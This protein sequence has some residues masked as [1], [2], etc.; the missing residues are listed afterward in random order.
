[1]EEGDHGMSSVDNRIVN[2]QF[3]NK[4]FVSGAEDSAQ[5]LDTLEKSI[6]G[7]SSSDS[8][9]SELGASVDT[10]A[11]RFGALQ[12]AGIAALATIASQATQTA[13]S[14]GRDLLGSITSTIFG[15]GFARAKD[16]QQAKFQFRGLGLDVQ[17][18]MDNASEAVD[19]TAFALNEAASIATQFGGSGVKAG[20]DMTEA[21]RAVSG[22]A[23]QTGRSYS[24][25]G[26]VMTGIAGVG[27]VTS[28]DIIQ[29]GVRGLDVIGP[30]AEQLGKTRNQIKQMVTDGQIDFKTFAHAMD[31]AFGENATK[32]NRTFTG[33]LANMQTA[34]K[35]IGADFFTGLLKPAGNVFN[36][37]QAVFKK[38]QEVLEPVSGGFAKVARSVSD[39]TVK[40]LESIHV[41]HLLG[42]ILQ[43][44]HNLF[45]PIVALFHTIGEAWLE[46]FPNSQH[47]SRRVL[48]TLAS[49]FKLITT[50]LEWLAKLIPF[51]SPLFVAFFEILRV[52][53]VAVAGLSDLIVKLFN[54]LAAGSDIGGNLIQGLIDGIQSGDL[55]QAIV[56]LA[57]NIIT[58]IKDVLGIHS[59]AESM[60]EIGTNIIMGIIDGL[61]AAVGFLWQTL[62]TL[63]TGIIEGIG[64]AFS[65][66]EAGDIAALI[67]AALLGGIFVAIRGVVKT[68]GR[69]ADSLSKISTTLTAPF[70]LLTESLKV[71]QT[72]V[73]A[74]LIKSIAIA[75]GILTVSL[76]ALSLM[77]FDKLKKGLG[78]LASEL[79]LIIGTMAALGKINPES[80]VASGAAIV[81]IS[82]AMVLLTAAL[83]GLALIPADQIGKALTTLAISLT[84][85]VGAVEFLGSIGPS[86]LAGAGA[87]AIVAAAMIALATAVGAFAL[88]PADQV[89]KA[90]TTLAISL[91]LVV[92][93]VAGLGS[94][95][96]AALAGAGGIFIVAQAMIVLAAAVFAF[97][98][99]NPNKVGQALTTMAI[100][101][102]EIVAALAL[103]TAIGPEVIASAGAIIIMA[104]AMKILADAIAVMA[105]VGPEKASQALVT[106][107]VALGIF[108]AAAAIAA[109][110]PVAVGLGVLASAMLVFG[111][112][113]ALLG[114]G[115]LA[116]ATAFTLFT[117]V[118]AGGTA[119]I[120]SGITALLALLPELARQI[121][122]AIIVFIE[123][124][125]AAVPRLREAFGKIIKGILGTI[126]D[127]LPQIKKLGNEMLD[128]LF[129]VI[130]KNA[131]KFGKVIEVL[132]K[133][134]LHVLRE[135]VPE[136][137]RTG[138][139]II[140][141]V[142]RGIGD[143]L[144]GIIDAGTDLV[145]KFIRGMAEAGNRI[146]NAAAN[147]VIKFLHGIADTI[148]EKSDEFSDAGWDI[149]EAIAQGIYDGIVGKGVELATQ[150]ATILADKLPEWMKK[151]LGISSPS[152]VA[153]WIGEMFVTGLVLG[154]TDNITNAVA[155]AVQ[156]ANAVIAA[157][158]K[159]VRK[160]QTQARKEQIRAEKK[161]ARA[162]LS[163]R[164]AR[165]AEKEARKNPK[166]K[167]LQKAAT[168]ARKLADQQQKAADE[169]QRKADAAAQKVSD[170]QAFRDADKEG[171]ADILRQRAEDLTNRS[172]KKL[173]EANAAAKAAKKATGK[174]RDRLQREAKQDAA[175]AKKLADKAKADQKR[176]DDLS[177]D[178]VINR[179]KAVKKRREAEKQAAKRQEEF[180][181]STVEEQV[182]IL[183]S[184]ADAAEKRA[185][186]ERKQS[187]ALIHRARQVAKKDAERAQELLD[188]SERLAQ[189]AKDD[190]D[191]ADE[192]RNQAADLTNQ[193]T[194]GTVTSP[195]LNISRSALEDAA[196]AI[197]RYTK[198]LL[199]AEE[200]AMSATP[201][202]QFVQNNT[203]PESLS[204]TTIYRNTKNLLSAAEI[205]MAA[206]A[207]TG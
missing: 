7:I 166:N 8:G 200:A 69:F 160:A 54:S 178:A 5:A 134:G 119:V 71:M 180:D 169:A 15:G 118:F 109:I 30:L 131:P 55:E 159:V 197:D 185:K 85:M 106:M 16:I 114:I 112:G 70:D 97:S 51:V 140:E 136:Y 66:L 124:I 139:A 201:V 6:S 202:Y 13:L 113:V 61:Q 43:G 105:E 68:I 100:A 192:A 154:I 10:V 81:L 104:L 199:Q 89:G 107:A 183:Q 168:E 45:S 189:K 20:E 128:T 193:G 110:G 2:M 181:N 93:A 207:P 90:L 170:I 176:A 28:Q 102:V 91:V 132:I 138:A 130:I 206:P 25:I 141:G 22:I 108:L 14:L 47:Q 194:S 153:H 165:E 133:T 123:T 95:G 50:P 162:D 151:I 161:Q 9:I 179:I 31:Q 53:W 144:P 167:A 121:A 58:W 18:V 77:P 127:A 116:A 99:I 44:F 143:K 4:D 34:I 152:K 187:E 76:I 88:I 41:A 74:E 135:A 35:R 36:A 38:V 63:A 120:I 72:Q 75:V 40:F 150:A 73:R 17:E 198:S 171:K 148:R 60:I 87:I 137:V 56:D 49:A 39:S 79:G 186:A 156:L 195:Q 103:T 172:I 117:A 163:D 32:A 48:F 1:M 125:A 64:N 57:N 111:A 174:E 115:L 80:I 142:L 155:A 92:A 94:I 145:V 173:A 205:K 24:E 191:K 86:A 23:A 122:T 33:A 101:L 96:P 129:D 203:S 126:R 52:G 82:G 182:A 46:V 83:A 19:G 3:N 175:A 146:V 12:V 188:R 21:L 204:D 29:F 59:P 11:S 190:A 164:F 78:F 177:R 157:G 62:G 26:Q 98:Q 158:D 196:S 84:L 149:A 37:L 67:N 184:R 147:A 27:R 65:H 42:P